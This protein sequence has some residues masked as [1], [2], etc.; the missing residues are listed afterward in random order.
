MIHTDNH[1]HGHQIMRAID[2]VFTPVTMEVI[3]RS[4]GGVLL[5]GVVYENWT[6][7]GGSCLAHI[8]GFAPNWI[9]RDFLFVMFDYPFVQLDCNQ[10]FGQV[11]SKNQHSIDF[12]KK[13]GWEEVI[14]LEGVFP[15]GDMILMRYRRENCRFLGIKPRSI[16]PRVNT[17]G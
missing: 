11:H 15:D 14:T 6:G 2:S 4:E 16:K 7:A 5:G 1:D 3:S 13:L 12:N 9:N 17:N 8:A 10:V